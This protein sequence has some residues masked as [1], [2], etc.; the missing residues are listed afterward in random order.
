MYIYNRINRF[1]V[2]EPLRRFGIDSYKIKRSKPINN[3]KIK[4]VHVLG[5]KLRS[6]TGNRRILKPLTKENIEFLTQ[7]GYKVKN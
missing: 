1:Q 3:I 2:G 6:A 5:S 7:L 4:S